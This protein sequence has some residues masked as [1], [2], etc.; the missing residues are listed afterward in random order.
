MA[1]PSSAPAYEAEMDQQSATLDDA[2]LKKRFPPHVLKE[3]GYFEHYEKS[4]EWYFDPERCKRTCLDDYQRLVLRKDIFYLDWDS[5]QSRLNTYKEDLEYICYCQALEN[6]IKWTKVHMA[7]GGTLDWSRVE[8]VAFIQALKI[9]ERF[10]TIS[11]DSSMS[12]FLDLLT[13]FRFN[14][15]YR[16]GLDGLYFEVWKRVATQK[17]D[18][19]AALSEIQKENLFPLRNIDIECELENEPGRLKLKDGCVS[20]DEGRQL[21][22][23]AVKKMVQIHET[24]LDYATKKVKVAKDIGVIRETEVTQITEEMIVK[25]SLQCWSVKP[26][27]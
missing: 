1:W 5:Y 12:G 16:D 26:S 23:E 14:H 4:L 10:P 21:I 7:P 3:N 11:L 13:I 27:E 24:Y 9:A 25:Q 6:A 8:G 20:T 18:F 22:R 17:M 15:H 2:N 19:R